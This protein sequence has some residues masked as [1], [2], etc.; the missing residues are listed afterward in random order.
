[1]QV[2]LSN[3][4]YKF[5]IIKKIYSTGILVYFLNPQPRKCL[6][7]FLEIR[8][9]REREE[10]EKERDRERERYPSESDISK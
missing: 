2:F 9:G 6:L 4:I 7:I 5:F 8:E 3:K 10:E 1:M